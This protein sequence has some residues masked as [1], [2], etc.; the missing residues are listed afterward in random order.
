MSG[1]DSKY[2]KDV[3]EFKPDRFVEYNSGVNFDG[4]DLELIPFGAG[5]RIC[6]GMSFG[7]AT[8]KIALANLLYHFNWELACEKPHELDMT[9][10]FGLATRRKMPLLLYAQPYD[11]AIN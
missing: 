6:P 10:T 9:E 11:H 3:D 2:W 7:L 4:N 5:R 8:I 1:R